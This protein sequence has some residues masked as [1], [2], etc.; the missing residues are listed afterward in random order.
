[1]PV[2]NIRDI[3]PRDTVAVEVTICRF[4]PKNPDTGISR[5]KAFLKIK[6]IS[7]IY[8]NTSAINDDEDTAKDL[9]D[10]ENFSL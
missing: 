10:D 7:L 6:S 5:S 1:M 4:W 3:K 2:H 8:A 9:S